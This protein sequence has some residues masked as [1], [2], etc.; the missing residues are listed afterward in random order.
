MMC[1]SKAHLYHVKVVGITVQMPPNGAAGCRSIRLCP[2]Q[3]EITQQTFPEIILALKMRIISL[4]MDS[5]VPF[6]CV[7]VLKIKRQ[8]VAG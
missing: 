1:G 8:S 4:N 7:I 6:V 3:Q 5:F 2:G